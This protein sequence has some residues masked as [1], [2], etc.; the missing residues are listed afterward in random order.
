M[1]AKKKSYRLVRIDVSKLKPGLDNPEIIKYRAKMEKQAE[2]YVSKHFRVLVW[3]RRMLAS[4]V[5]AG[6]VYRL[7]HAILELENLDMEK[8]SFIE[9]YIWKYMEADE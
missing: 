9:G 1:T 5:D 4:G 7:I 8:Q 3:I 6:Q 2:K